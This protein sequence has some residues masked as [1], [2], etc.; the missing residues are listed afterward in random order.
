MT[1]VQLVGTAPD[2]LRVEGDLTAA[3]VGALLERL[4]VSGDV[5]RVSLAGVRGIDSAGLALLLE[6]QR[7]LDDHQGTLELTAVPES[8]R[9][10]ARISSV[11]TLLDLEATDAENAG[12]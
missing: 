10:L 2:G 8:L 5:H 4:P 9:A 12:Q 3:E 6:W 11:A 1:A 7:R